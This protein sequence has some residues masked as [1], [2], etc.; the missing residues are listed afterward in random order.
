MQRPGSVEAADAPHLA[1]DPVF[2]GSGTFR[3]PPATS[4]LAGAFWFGTRLAVLIGVVFRFPPAPKGPLRM[5]CHHR[6][7]CR[8]RAGHWPILAAFAAASCA[9]PGPAPAAPIIWDAPQTI[10]GDSDVS[11]SGTLVYAYTL[12]EEGVPSTTVNGVLFDSFEFLVGGTSTAVG[13]VTFSESPGVLDA[14]LG[15]G[16]TAAPFVNLSAAYRVLLTSGGFASDVG[17]ITATLGDLTTGQQYLLQVWTS[18]A[19]LFTPQSGT[20]QQT[21]LTST[22]QVTLDANTTDLVGGLGQFVTGQFTADAPTQE[23]T[24]SGAIFPANLPLINALQ[25]RAVPVPEPSTCCLILAGLASAGCTLWRRR[26]RAWHSAEGG[27]FADGA[28]GTSSPA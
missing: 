14:S 22:N 7:A 9:V 24:L 8:R 20:L 12:G 3:C 19:A 13:S 1:K 4:L 5:P 27:T 16:S 11:T 18:N 23:F 6:P 10:S 17:V 28:T 2:L 21:T 26:R 25:V 15:L